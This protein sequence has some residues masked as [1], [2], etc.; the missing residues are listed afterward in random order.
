MPFTPYFA[1]CETVPYL[2][3]SLLMLLVNIGGN[4]TMENP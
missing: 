2:S 1:I 3:A 4:P